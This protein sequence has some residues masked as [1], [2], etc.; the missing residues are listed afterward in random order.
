MNEFCHYGTST[1]VVSVVKWNVRNRKMKDRQRKYFEKNKP[2][3][4]RTGAFDES[5]P[6][7]SSGVV[8]TSPI[9][10]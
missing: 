9:S 3:E 8:F 6:A 10:I 2:Q 1:H 4:E 5:L 7:I